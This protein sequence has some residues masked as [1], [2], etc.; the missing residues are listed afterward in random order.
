[1]ARNRSGGA[2]ALVAAGMAVA[3]VGITGAGSALA[4]QHTDQLQCGN[5]TLEI[6]T[7]DNN[8]S[9]HGGWSVAQVTADKAGTHLIPV[10]FEGSA[11]DLSV[12]GTPE[13]FSFSAAKG[14][15]NANRNLPTTT[16]TLTF[17][18]TWTEVS[19]GGAP[20]P[21]VSP[22]DMIEVTFTATVVQKG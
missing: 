20:P 13:V 11:V 3:C 7:N 9:D 12:A 22:T 15:G 18:G 8:S 21:G 19:E 1:M 14:A 10:A 16:C 17:S 4:A 5:T 6:R 2:R